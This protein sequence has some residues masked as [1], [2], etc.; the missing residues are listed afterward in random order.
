VSDVATPPEP[1]M[2]IHKPKPFHNWRE[3]F[4]EVGII[5]LGVAIAL[6]GEQGVEWLHNRHRAAQAGEG[7]RHE[8]AV[9]IGHMITRDKFEPCVSKRLDEIEGLI[10]AAAAGKL[11]PDSIWIGR[12]YYY[13][14]EDSEYRTATQ[15]GAADLLPDKERATIATIYNAFNQYSQA[16][17]REQ[18]AWSDLRV[19]EK[20][21][22]ASPAL[23]W[24]L[25]S[26]LQR[27]RTAR[28]QEEAD[29][30]A[31]AK[32]GAGA[33]GIAAAPIFNFTIQSA[34]IALHTPRAKAEE[35]IVNG[36]TP[37]VTYDEP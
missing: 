7:I 22:A 30:R 10:A 8:I 26:A 14:L 9:G 5:V 37:R 21:P 27:A 34:C 32:T 18:E 12:P 11:P 31:V 19:L 35:M 1:K 20:H 3:F 33:L 17:Q 4:K 16:E 29:S 23:E 36:R 24:Q 15:S 2:E 13:A 28:W 6:A 25:R